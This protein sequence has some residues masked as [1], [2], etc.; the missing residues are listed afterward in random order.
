MVD[1]NCHAGHILLS[2]TVFSHDAEVLVVPRVP[3]SRTGA[4]AFSYSVV[5][6]HD[7]NLKSWRGPFKKGDLV[8]TDFVNPVKQKRSGFS[9]L[10]RKVIW[11]IIRIKI[12]LDIL[13][14]KYFSL[15]KACP[16]VEHAMDEEAALKYTELNIRVHHWRHVQVAP[17]GVFQI[18]PVWLGDKWSNAQ[19][20]WW[21]LLNL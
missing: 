11:I 6:I 5:Y 13:Y 9:I 1:L 10:E 17:L 12:L 18:Y 4:N 7:P 2:K 15:N 20:L 19:K 16:F 14:K 21:S 8:Q 3:K